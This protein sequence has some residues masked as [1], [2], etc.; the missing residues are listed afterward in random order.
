[1][2]RSS[3]TISFGML[4]VG[5]ST[6]A[7]PG[8][9]CRVSAMHMMYVTLYVRHISCLTY[10]LHMLYAVVCTVQWKGK[11]GGIAQTSNLKATCRWLL[12]LR[13]SVNGSVLSE[14]QWR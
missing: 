4:E 6:V 7:A 3:P 12:A 14:G 1:M 2:A 10:A 9:M 5:G 8:G 11:D 13:Q